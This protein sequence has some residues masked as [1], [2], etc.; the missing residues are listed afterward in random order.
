MGTSRSCKQLRSHPAVSPPAGKARGSN[1]SIAMKSWSDGSSSQT[2]SV[3]RWIHLRWSAITSS[4]SRSNGF[5]RAT[6]CGWPA[7]RR[8]SSRAPCR[9]YF[10]RSSAGSRPCR[11]FII[12][13]ARASVCR[14]SS[15]ARRDSNSLREIRPTGPT[16]RCASSAVEKR[17]PVLDGFLSRPIEMTYP[18]GRQSDTVA[19]GVEASLRARPAPAH[20]N[21]RSWRSATRIAIPAIWGTVGARPIRRNLQRQS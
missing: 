16:A 6:E 3:V 19:T 20:R 4:S 1:F 2:T 21:I 12:C 17:D 13:R 18:R 7:V 14:T 5:H 11:S 9:R 10:V 8:A 15:S